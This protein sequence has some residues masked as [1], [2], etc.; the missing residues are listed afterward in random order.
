MPHDVLD[1]DTLALFRR[2]A[3]AHGLDPDTQYRDGLTASQEEPCETSHPNPNG[4]LG[5]QVLPRHYGCARTLQTFDA[6]GDRNN[7]YWRRLIVMY[8]VL[9]VGA[10]VLLRVQTAKT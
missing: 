9:R 5:T 8:A 4:V 1:I 3:L 7:M 6:T 2:T 10:L